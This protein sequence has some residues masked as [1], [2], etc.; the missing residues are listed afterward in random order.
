M[1]ATIP[2][3]FPKARRH[4]NYVGVG[5]QG[6][7]EIGKQ[8]TAGTR[9]ESRGDAHLTQSRGGEGTVLTGAAPSPVPREER[10]PTDSLLTP[11]WTPKER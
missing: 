9:P 11:P 3:R 10:E 4:L 1:V 6:G 5:Q 7:E 2:F 8:S